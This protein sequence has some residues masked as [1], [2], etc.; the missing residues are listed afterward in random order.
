VRENGDKLVSTLDVPFLSVAVKRTA[1]EATPLSQCVESKRSTDRLLFHDSR[2]MAEH[3]PVILATIDYYLPGYKGGG[4]LQALAN[5]VSRLGD[6]WEFKIVTRDRDLGDASAYPG[7]P[8][9]SWYRVG[10]AEVAYLAPVRRLW[11]LLKL[12]REV[13]FDIL[14]LNSCFSP[15]FTVGLLLFRKLGLIGVRSVVIA[16]RGELSP[17]AIRIKRLK[18]LGYLG[19]AKVLGLYRNVIWQVSTE[20]E[21]NDVEHHWGD[22]AQVVIA[23]DCLPSMKES[24]VSFP[25]R[26]KQ[27]GKADIVFLSR[28]SRKKNLD[29]ALTMLKGLEGDVCFSIYGPKEDLEYWHECQ[30]IID[31]LPAHIRIE[32]C[33]PVAHEEIL[34]VLAK[35]HLLFFPTHSEN[36][37]FVILEALLAGCPVLI[38]D[39]TPWRDLQA[40]RVGWELPLTEPERFR[41]VL[42]GCIDMDQGTFS[43]LVRN[44][45]EYGKRILR[46]DPSVEESIQLFERAL[47]RC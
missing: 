21:K 42:Q 4:P 10:K 34:P 47:A 36:F 32:Y 16:P 37:G 9:G 35:H 31:S 7:V 17:G 12:M 27:K 26:K 38:S 22:N 14:Y 33:G 39:Q 15:T 40:K 6:T 25:M 8:E 45:S 11:R 29:G 46:E 41:E 1:Y 19:M 24:D 23:H 5:M 2:D 3:R 28:I 44:A 30:N 13:E 43:D 20:L 18:K